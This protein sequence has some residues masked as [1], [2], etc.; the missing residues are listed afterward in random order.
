[1]LVECLHPPNLCLRMLHEVELSYKEVPHI[2]VRSWGWSSSKLVHEQLH[3]SQY[4]QS[5]ISA[6][7]PITV[8]NSHNLKKLEPSN[9]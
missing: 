4:L 9:I 5:L 7:S 3:E 2:L 6:T 1:M 8:G